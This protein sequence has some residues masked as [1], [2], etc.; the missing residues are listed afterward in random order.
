MERRP[1]SQGP[2]LDLSVSPV[3]RPAGGGS[4]KPFYIFSHPLA[5]LAFNTPLWLRKIWRHRWRL[6]F[7]FYDVF[8]TGIGGVTGPRQPIRRLIVD[9]Q[10]RR[11]R[12]QANGLGQSRTRV[13]L[14][15]LCAVFIP[16]VRSA[17]TSTHSQVSREQRTSHREERSMLRDGFS[18]PHPHGH[19]IFLDIRHGVSSLPS[20]PSMMGMGHTLH[21]CTQP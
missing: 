19:E 3:G 5:L 8:T 18:L 4:V 12:S 16:D 17:Q 20:F 2:P 11:M 15:T 13:A 6:F 14:A 1:N 9:S 21:L 7:V 10:I